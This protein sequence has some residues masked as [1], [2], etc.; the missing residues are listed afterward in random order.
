V[1]AEGRAAFD[2]N[3]LG[4]SAR[5]DRG[6]EAKSK[7][8]TAVEKLE[9]RALVI[10]GVAFADSVSARAAGKDVTAYGRVGLAD[11]NMDV[12]VVVTDTHPVAPDPQPAAPRS[13]TV[14]GPWH[15]PVVRMEDADR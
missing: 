11:G 14:R 8:S 6:P 12:R 1:L 2:I 3:A 10:D 4:A 7:G 9:A 5:T 15:A 13:L